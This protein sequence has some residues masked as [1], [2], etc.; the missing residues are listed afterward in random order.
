MKTIY[1]L[2]AFVLLFIALPS[3]AQVR[4]K[5]CIGCGGSSMLQSQTYIHQATGQ[6]FQPVKKIEDYRAGFVFV[7]AAKLE[8]FKPKYDVYPNPTTSLVHIKGEVEDC[9]IQLLDMA[10]RAIGY[11]PMKGTGQEYS[12]DLSSAAKGTYLIVIEHPLYGNQAYKIIKL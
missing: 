9:K 7:S 10:G 4:M 8:R 1:S 2:I 6:V 3:N 11:E 12:L 5:S